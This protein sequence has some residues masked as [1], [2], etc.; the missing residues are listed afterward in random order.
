MNADGI[1]AYIRTRAVEH[2][3]MLGEG[4]ASRFI[5][6]VFAVGPSLELIDLAARLNSPEVLA[7]IAEFAKARE[8]PPI[9]R[10]KIPE[11]PWSDPAIARRRARLA[12]RGRTLAQIMGAA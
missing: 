9:P 5:E 7:A 11:P 4:E 12:R 3:V 2:E 10:L 6:R 1:H 8:A